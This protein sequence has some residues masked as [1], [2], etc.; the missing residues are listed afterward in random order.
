VAIFFANQSHCQYLFFASREQIRLVENFVYATV[1]KTSRVNHEN[2]ALW[3]RFS[4]FEYMRV[5]EHGNLKN[6]KRIK[7]FFCMLRNTRSKLTFPLGY[8]YIQI[9]K[10][11]IRFSSGKQTLKV[12]LVIYL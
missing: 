4:S 8:D 2:E 9:L 12:C 3:P 5:S 7:R 11:L 1:V 10:F 6:I